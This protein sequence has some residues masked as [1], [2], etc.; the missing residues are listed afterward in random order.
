MTRARGARRAP[1]S[2]LVAL[3]ALV[4]LQGCAAGGPRPPANDDERRLFEEEAGISRSPD[5]VELR[6]AASRRCLMLV[7]WPGSERS[8]RLQY[9][10][11]ALLHADAVVRLDGDR[12]EGHFYR[13][14]SLGRILEL[15]RFPNPAQIGQL[16]AAGLRA[17]ELDPGFSAGGPLRLLAMLYHRA[18][19]WPI[20]PE[21]AGEDEVIE[22]LFLEA[23]R[24]GP[25][26]VENRVGYAEYLRDRSR[27]EDARAQVRAAREHFDA[28]PLLV[29]SPHERPALA[30]RLEALERKLTPPG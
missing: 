26:C 11:R 28:D 12:V 2:A 3:G 18:P 9:A 5:D 20:G 27:E 4:A 14:V 1:L 25:R 7:D 23:I 16:E 13:A 15:S 29:A 8:D 24:L 21:D 6:I 22:G 19:A 30:Q 10:E 17:R